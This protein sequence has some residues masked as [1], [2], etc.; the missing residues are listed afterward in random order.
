VSDAPHDPGTPADE[1]GVPDARSPAGRLRDAAV[2]LGVSLLAFVAGL[3][4]FNFVLMPRFVH[5]TG[6]IEVPDLRQL[7]FEQAERTIE[8]SGLTLSRAGERFDPSVPRGFV[9]AQDPAP[10]T[11]VRGNRRVMVT[12][13]LGEESSSVP[14]LSGE[15]RRN[16]E[17]L[18]ARAGLEVG[19]VTRARSE[20]VGEGLV[21]A[22]DP[23]AETVLP[24][25]TPVALLLSTG[26]GPEEHVM[27]DLV[28]REI[29]GVRR[30]LEAL[31][32]RVLT[33]P[34][35]A[36]VGPIVAQDPPPG[37][38]IGRDAVI[39]LQAAGRVIR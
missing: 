28:G 20:F 1:A 5:T 39:T 12:L 22:T 15:S 30:Q 18:L 2:L 16:A 14:E 34:G 10:G 9:L 31:G 8:P 13:S 32:L 25:A 3:A 33:A 6:T 21:V 4:V 26:P 35:A 36:E 11:P 29:G 37:A 19:A 27:P 17:L 24:R 38:R 7:T 23:P